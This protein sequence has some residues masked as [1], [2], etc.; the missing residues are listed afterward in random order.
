V[1]IEGLTVPVIGRDEL[2]RNKIAS[3]R[4]KDLADLA[5]LGASHASKKPSPRKSVRG[6][7]R[8]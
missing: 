3:G 6:K 4:P 5:A 8:R 7:R 1:A 2:V